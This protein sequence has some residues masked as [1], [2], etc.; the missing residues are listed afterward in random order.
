MSKLTFKFG[1]MAAAKTLELLVTCHQYEAAG[2][3][4]YLIKP[5]VDTRQSGLIWSRVPGMQRRVDLEV[6][7]DTC[8]PAQVWERYDVIL[9]DECHWFSAEFVR[10]L[11]RVS[12]HMP[13]VCYGLRTDFRQ[14][15][16]PGSAA[17]FALA[18]ELLEIRGL[19]RFCPRTAAHNMR[20]S[21]RPPPQEG[22]TFE[23]GAD[24]TFV[25]VCQKCYHQGT[26]SVAIK[27]QKN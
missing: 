21:H 4:P 2:K 8:L 19:C 7:D 1:T 14:Q 17:L 24:E 6:A 23:L 3:R 18:D 26:S 15:L 11:H 22:S 20:V 16:F 9:A 12:I 25:P 27:S 10:E 13:V 5:A